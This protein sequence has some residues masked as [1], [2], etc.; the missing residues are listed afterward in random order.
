MVQEETIAAI[1][2]ATGEAG[3]G[4]VRVSGGEALEKVRRLFYDAYGRPVES[5]PPRRMLY[6]QIRNPENSEVV[7]EVLMV[8]MKAPHTYTREDVV[9][10]QCHGGT[11][12]VRRI[13]ALLLSQGIRG[14]VPGEFTKRAF[15]NGRLD[16]S[17]A[18]AVM[19]LISAR[20]ERSHQAAMDQLEGF[21]SR[22]VRFLRGRMLALLAEM[23]VSIDFSEEEDVE[24]ATYDS[25]MKASRELIKE[26]DGLI[27]SARTGKI[28]REGIKTIIVGK[29]NVGKSSLLNAL[30]RESRAIVTDIPGTTRDAIEEQ[31]NLKGIPMVLMDT[32]GIRETEDLVEQLGVERTRLLFEKADLVIM[33]LDAS[34]HLSREDQE[35][36]SMIKNKK[37]LILVNKTDL[38]SLFSETELP[39]WVDRNQLL[40]ISLL[41][42]AGMEALEEALMALVFQGET[43]EQEKE[44]VTNLRHQQA[45]EV[46]R[47]ALQDG[48]QALENQLPLD[49]LQVD[50][51]TA[52]DSLG[53]I[54]GETVREDL[55]DFIF[56]HFC[57]GK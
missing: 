51:Q 15:L 28:L 38:P 39:D 27:A 23:E 48:L 6:G 42:E 8:Y 5:L 52:M 19:D 17:Q 22:K 46:A 14:A 29:P 9:E 7:D 45:L 35:I 41:E 47:K 16:L 10:I 55:V 13:M 20:T 54:I 3:I 18:E 33:M 57:I 50:Y 36:I 32:A 44:M 12:S 40:R 4:I 34:T 30:L 2:T 24:V 43:R 11:Q 1:A 21:L 26:I 31:L 53:E 37:T 49:F 25:L 56:S